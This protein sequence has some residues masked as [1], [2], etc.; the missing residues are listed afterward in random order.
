MATDFA[1]VCASWAEQQSSPPTIRDFVF[2]LIDHCHIDP[3]T[4]MS[5]EEY[6]ACCEL[7]HASPSQGEEAL[8]ESAW[9]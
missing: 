8:M 6:A 2:W 3:G 1:K 5:D 7:L 4:V 9:P